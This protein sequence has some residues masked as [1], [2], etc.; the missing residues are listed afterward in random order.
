MQFVS[1]LPSGVY[2]GQTRIR[3]PGTLA[4]E[5]PELAGFNLALHVRMIRSEYKLTG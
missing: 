4:S 2:A 3:H 5:K 1:G